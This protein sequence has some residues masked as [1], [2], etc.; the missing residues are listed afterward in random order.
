[1]CLCSRFFFSQLKANTT[2]RH[3]EYPYISP[4]G[5]E[6]NFIL[7]A[8]KP[9]VF[10]ALSD[11]GTQLTYAGNEGPGARSSGAEGWWL[12][13]VCRAPACVVLLSAP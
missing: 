7:P 11:D 5:K 10:D 12:C 9:V 3:P 4:C 6:M 13:C 2:G 8:D 1:M